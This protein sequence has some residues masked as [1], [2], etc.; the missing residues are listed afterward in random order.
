[1]TSV[2]KPLVLAPTSAKP[3]TCGVSDYLHRLA[4][5]VNAQEPGLMQ[6]VILETERPLHFIG[7]LVRHLRA[8]GIVHMNL[9][10]EGWGQ[11]LLPGAV[12]ALVRCL[13]Q[14]GRI[15]LTLHEWLSLHPLRYAS[16]LPDIHVADAVVLVSRQQM[17]AFQTQGRLVPPQL[18]DEARLIP[19]GPNL[20]PESVPAPVPQRRIADVGRKGGR[21]LVIGYFGVLY[22]SKQPILMLEALAA[23]ARRGVD[24]ELRICGDF[25]H[26]KPQEKAAF[27]A[28]VDRLG[29]RDRIDMRG[30][31]EKQADVLA[32]LAETD[33]N[34]L[35][36]SDG[37][38][39]RRSSLLTCLQLDR[40]VVTTQ[41][42]EADEFADW[43]QLADQIAGGGIRLVA[44]DADGETVAA[45]IDTFAASEPRRDPV[46]LEALWQVAASEH[47]A[48]YAEVAARPRRSL[49]GRRR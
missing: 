42:Q 2:P 19:I 21:R 27:N 5:F 33:L 23:L 1:M 31:I 49:F 13:T 12:L 30:R 43:P 32:A 11:H 36:F 46:D 34:L 6:V 3:V 37:A 7:T 20:M 15:V 47:R 41:P 22:T 48:L 8:G 44:P 28:A 24:A 17:R 16:E 39:T 45:A 18:R 9:P 38:S 10:V 14:R 4:S 25:L 26:D 40:P 35:L 29:V